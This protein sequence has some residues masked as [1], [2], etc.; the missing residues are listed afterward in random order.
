MILACAT[1]TFAA[2]HVCIHD[3]IAAKYGA[4]NTRVV[5]QNYNP[6]N[7]LSS[8]G[9]QPRVITSWNNI[10]ITFDFSKLQVNSDGDRSCYSAGAAFRV[11]TPSGGST[12]ACSSSVTDDCW[13]TCS[14]G[15]VVTQAKVDYIQTSLI[16]AAQEWLQK[17]LMVKRVSGNLILSAGSCGSSGGVTIPTSYTTTGV[18]NTDL[19]IFVTARPTFG[20]TLAWATDCQQDSK[21]R[22]IAGQINFGPA[23]LSTSASV[24]R[25]W[26][27]MLAFLLFVLI[28]VPAECWYR[29]P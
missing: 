28:G 2:E 19:L 14:S 4:L 29:D 7:T 12:P 9:F 25:C 10:R 17:A 18:S 5:P 16:P 15:D 27:S 11:G 23:A 6:I 13:G 1:L 24:R 21:H 26:L 20:N 22:P 3:Q 8:G